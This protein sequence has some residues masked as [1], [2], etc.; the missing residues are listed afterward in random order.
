MPLLP[1]AHKE[2]EQPCPLQPWKD[3][4]PFHKDIWAATVIQ[5]QG[6]A[7]D[8]AALSSVMD[9]CH[10]TDSLTQAQRRVGHSTCGQNGMP[11]AWYPPEHVRMGLS[12]WLGKKPPEH[13]AESWRIPE[14][15]GPAD[16]AVYH[17]RLV[18]T[19]CIDLDHRR[20]VARLAC[21]SERL[22]SNPPTSRHPQ[23][24]DANAPL[25]LA[26]ASA[27]MHTASPIH[28]DN[29]SALASRSPST[30]TEATSH[31]SHT[32]QIEKLL[33]QSPA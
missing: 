10:L 3:G 23:A 5:Q 15:S 32:T 1:G 12:G 18:G 20:L 19:A 26:S 2:G 7:A 6:L 22:G 13:R 4:P 29:R 24:A 31:T 16:P 28:T 25:L 17:L 27:A 14:V 33:A 21:A 30:C 11:T 8:D 9:V